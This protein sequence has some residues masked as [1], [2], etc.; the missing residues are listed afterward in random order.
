MFN[1]ILGFTQML[2]EELPSLRLDEVQKMALTMR[3]SATNLYGMLE[4]PL[5][6]SCLER[7]LII[8]E[9]TSFLLMTKISENMISA[10]ES[11]KKKTLI[12][13]IPSLETWLFLPM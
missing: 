11:V 5:E 6:W 12:S 10:A 9:P 4:N 7:G 13:S 8:C 3:K 2:V 1:S